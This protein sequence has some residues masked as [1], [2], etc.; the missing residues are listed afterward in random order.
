MTVR[1]LKNLLDDYEEQDAQ[2]VI[3]SDEEGNDVITEVALEVFECEEDDE[4]DCHLES[5]TVIL[6]PVDFASGW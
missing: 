3:F 4:E 1:E 2:V 5:G 6:V